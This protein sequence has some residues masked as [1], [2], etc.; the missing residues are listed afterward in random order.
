MSF[1]NNK[2]FTHIIIIGGQRCG[3]TYLLNLLKTSKQFLL[4]DKILPEPK[5][6]LQKNP[7][8]INYLKKH[9]K[10]EKNKN[11]KV[12]VEKSTSYYENYKAL[13]KINLILDNYYLIL[14][15]RDPIKRAISNYAMSLKNGFEN[16]ELNQAFSRELNNQRSTSINFIST[17]P[18]DYIGR[19]MYM[20][21]IKNILE[22][23]PKDRL[24]VKTSESIFKNPKVIFEVLNKKGIVDLKYGIDEKSFFKISK[25]KINNLSYDFNSLL[26]KD[27]NMKLVNLFAEDKEFLIEN[28]NLDLTCWH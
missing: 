12:L 11:E 10:I 17:D 18:Q 19:S 13:K 1:L 2:Q 20:K 23:I 16:F 7:T 24:I 5:Y 8:Y 21:K 15:L 3:T 14:I 25:Q 27:I 9:F 22:I 6:F 4:S 26:N 28:F